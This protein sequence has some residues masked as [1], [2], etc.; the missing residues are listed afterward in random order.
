MLCLRS[1]SYSAF[2]E[3]CRQA[4]VELVVRQ[5]TRNVA[6]QVWLVSAGL[7]IAP[8]PN[9]PDLENHPGVTLVGLPRDAPVG[10]IVLAWRRS[11]TS[12]ALQRFIAVA[13]A[14]FGPPRG[15]P[16]N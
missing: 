3:R 8:L 9:V 7:G 12:P 15:D 6:T 1:V 10:E 13:K 5:Y 14:S 11:D 2:H 4:D 16:G